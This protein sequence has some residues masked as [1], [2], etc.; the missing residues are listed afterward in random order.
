MGELLGA[1]GGREAVLARFVGS[2]SPEDER[3]LIDLLAE[4]RHEEPEAP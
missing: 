1:A 4:G 2:L 3:L